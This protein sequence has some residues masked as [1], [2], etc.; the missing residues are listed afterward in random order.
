MTGPGAGPSEDA[1]RPLRLAWDCTYALSS[2][3]GVG[4]FADAVLSRFAADRQMDVRGYAVA[5][6]AWQSASRRVGHGVQVGWRSRALSPRWARAAWRRSALPPIEWVTGRVDVAHS[7]NFMAPPTR[8]AAAVATVHDLTFIRH[9][10]WCTTDTVDWFP[11]LIAAAVARG[12]WIHTVSDAVRDEVCEAFVVDPERVRT[13]PN[14]VDPLPEVPSGTGRRI[15]GTD[16]YLLALGTIEPRKNLGR[17]VAAFDLVAAADPDLRLVVAGSPGWGTDDFDAAL[18][19]SPHKERIIRTGWVDPE[20]R[21]GLLRDATGLTYVSLYEG[22]G[23]PPLEAMSVGTPVV[24]SSVP[25]LRETCADA[26]EFVDPLDVDA[27]AAGLAAV[28]GDSTRAS[29]LA[30]AG[31]RRVRDFSWD[32]TAQGLRTLYVDAI[33]ERSGGRPTGRPTG[34]RAS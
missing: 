10:E 4:T 6:P 33:D 3:T 5:G 25:A 21:A 8:R 15:A 28:T 13:V 9:P 26:A 12:A 32:A 24:A 20:S 16:R 19:A 11:P 31:N 14:A 23:I 2:L 27:I 34:R 29:A 1:G 18:A 7:P 22:F 17:L 30:A